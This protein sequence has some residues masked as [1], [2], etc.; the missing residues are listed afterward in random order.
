MTI[1]VTNNDVVLLGHGSYLGGADNFN[2]PPE[3]ELY[4]LQPAG[5]TLECGVAAA[6]IRQESIAKLVLHHANGSGNSDWVPAA[7]YR[8][9]AL[10]PDLILHNLESL[11]DWG[12]QV[13]GPRLNVVTVDRD[14][15]LSELLGG[16]HAIRAAIAREVKAGRKLRL[17]WSAC[18]NQVSGNVARL[19]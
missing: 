10:A 15:R 9:G 13:I 6:L 7:P 16:N 12:R 14:I 5:Y 3:V 18:A 17:F 1:K 4:I 8:D 2:L 11:A 19:Q